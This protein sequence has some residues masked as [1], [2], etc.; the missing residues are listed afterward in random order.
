MILLQPSLLAMLISTAAAQKAIYGAMELFP[1]GLSPRSYANA[2]FAKRDGEP[3][4]ASS[5]RCTPALQSTTLETMSTDQS[6]SQR[7]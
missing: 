2:P 4:N 3:C 1:A 7:H 6:R 5:H